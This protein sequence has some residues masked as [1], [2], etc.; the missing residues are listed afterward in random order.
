[1]KITRG[2][3]AQ[4]GRKPSDFTSAVLH[5]DLHSEADLSEASDVAPRVYNTASVVHKQPGRM[6][7]DASAM[8][9]PLPTRKQ[10]LAHMQKT[11]VRN[12]SEQLPIAKALPNTQQA[13]SP[14]KGLRKVPITKA[15][16]E[17]LMFK[18]VFVQ[19]QE[20]ILDSVKTKLA[21]HRK[22]VLRRNPRLQMLLN[23][24][25]TAPTLLTPVQD[26]PHTDHRYFA[27]Q[28]QVQPPE[29][30]NASVAAPLTP[31]GGW[32]PSIPAG[33]NSLSQANLKDMTMR[34][35]AGVQAGDVQ[36]EAHMSYCLG[37]L[38]EQK[39]SYKEA[40]KFYKRFFFCAR[41]LDDPIG[42]A[43]GLN[44]LGVLYHNMNKHPKALQFH[45][46]H[47]ELSDKDNRFAALYNLGITHRQLSAFPDSL[48]V[49]T[50]ALA[51]A[52]DRQD[53]ESECISL[54]QMG[55][56]AQLQGDIGA[57]FEY[58]QTSLKLAQRLRSEKLQ[59]D[60]LLVLGEL[61][62]GMQKLPVAVSFYGAA[63][64]VRAM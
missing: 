29:G 27:Q 26:V 18:Q 2:A 14:Q 4:A 59:L 6:R 58:F 50:Q 20:E 35:T 43:L 24:P 49:L 55:L 42:A 3:T 54:G 13:G 12:A 15:E 53:A 57:S 36:K 39:R 62:F 5:S 63:I 1:M 60:T 40:A 9:A 64:S 21:E 16:G 38:N 23:R 30:L 56:T 45:L 44:R 8:I 61:A 37:V 31:G 34:A 52:R 7:K 47:L 17:L 28:I 10:Q 32:A 11:L 51:W 46:K 25:E 48:A 19:P 22:E 33:N 41:L